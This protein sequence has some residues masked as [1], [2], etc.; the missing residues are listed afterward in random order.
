MPFATIA[1]RGCGDKRTPGGMYAECGLGEHGSPLESFLVDPVVPLPSGLNL[2]NK[3]QL[4]EDR[5]TGLVHLMLWIGEQYY[6]HMADYIE[7]VRRFGASRRIPVTLDLSRLTPG[8]SRMILAHPRARVDNWHVL[9]PPHV[10]RKKVERHAVEAR[11]LLDDGKTVDGTVVG[12]E[13][14]LIGG[15]DDEP[16]FGRFG[17]AGPC[18][19]KT[20]DLI[21]AADGGFIGGDADGAHYIRH[22]ADTSYAYTPT[23]EEGKFSPAIFAALPLHGFSVVKDNE[24]NVNERAKE[25]ASAS[26]YEWRAT[27]E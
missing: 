11:A 1:R 6:P 20:Y 9:T 4:W 23:G 14:A 16:E 8:R 26:G 10:C 5:R 17:Q 22:I 21:P 25:K 24:G 12:Q 2:V 15:W 3:P 13:Q 19:Y 7:E 18:L 27:D